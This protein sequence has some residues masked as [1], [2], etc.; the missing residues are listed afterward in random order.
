MLLKMLQNM[1]SILALLLATIATTSASEAK[2]IQEFKT[3]N[4]NVPSDYKNF[5]CDRG[6]CHLKEENKD[7]G[8]TILLA[9][10]YDGEIDEAHCA[11]DSEDL[12]G[13]LLKDHN[14]DPKGYGYGGINLIVEEG[15]TEG[16]EDLISDWTHEK[17]LALTMYLEDYLS[18]K[19]LLKDNWA[20]VLE[21]KILHTWINFK[22]FDDIKAKISETS[23]DSITWIAPNTDQG[24]QL[25]QEIPSNQ[26]IVVS[27]ETDFLRDAFAEEMCL[28]QQ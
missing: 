11:D 5:R 12:F 9:S 3:I 6:R 16:L 21:E 2:K 24:N 1:K 14:D 20:S 7:A 25:R 15:N 10:K 13:L 23:S 28:I 19:N 22:T 26:K 4:L 18:L 17:K 27:R 8:T